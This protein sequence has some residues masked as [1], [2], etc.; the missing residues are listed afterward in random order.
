MLMIL[1]TCYRRT[2]PY[3]EVACLRAI[4][5]HSLKHGFHD[6]YITYYF[7]LER[8]HFNWSDQVVPFSCLDG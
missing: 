1:F 5:H 2:L 3:Q 6:K 8:L 7:I 4:L